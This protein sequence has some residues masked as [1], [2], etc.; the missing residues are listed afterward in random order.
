MLIKNILTSVSDTYNFNGKDEV[1]FLNTGDIS[2][3]KMLHNNF[4]NISV[5]PG[6]AKKSIKNNDLLY[7]EIRPINRHY[8]LVKVNHPENYVVSTKLM[9]LRKKN[10]N[11]DMNYLYQFLISDKVVNDL[12][13][14]AESRSGTFPQITY[15]IL[16]T[17][18]IPDI[19]LQ[20]QQ[21]IV[22]IN[23]HCLIFVVILHLFLY[24]LQ[25]GLLIRVLTF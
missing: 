2:E 24:L 1:I 16:S 9:V 25:I 6:Q 4:T 5:L 14:M 19:S 13:S 3:G 22:N 11:Y 7:S 8:A 21:H 17:L 20:K 23:H 18:D 15:E 12:Q 10:D